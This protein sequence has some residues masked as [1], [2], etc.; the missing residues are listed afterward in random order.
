M[1]LQKLIPEKAFTTEIA[2]KG[3]FGLVDEGVLLEIRLRPERP[4]THVASK[5]F[6]PGVNKFV[7][8]KVT[9]GDKL[10]NGKHRVTGP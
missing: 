1:G 10:W 6:R 7:P 2:L 3:S 8:A 4:L 5:V 9:R